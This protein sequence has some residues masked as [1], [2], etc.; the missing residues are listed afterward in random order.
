M[1]QTGQSIKQAQHLALKTNA[2]WLAE[3]HLNSLR[4]APEWPNA[5]SSSEQL[6]MM[7]DDWTVATEVTTTSDP[8][9]RKIAVSMHLGDGYEGDAL[10]SLVG[11]RGRF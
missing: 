4:A 11:Y 5:G 2:L 7:G 8:W 6:S 10:I 9:L 1:S 3:N